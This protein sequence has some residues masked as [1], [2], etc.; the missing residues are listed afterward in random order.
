MLKLERTNLTGCEDR[1]ISRWDARWYAR[2]AY[3]LGVRY[4]GGCC[5]FQPFHVRA[6]AEELAAERGGRLPEASAMTDLGLAI[7]RKIGGDGG[8]QRQNEMY[9]KK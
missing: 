1:T 5:G 2:A 4:V 7:Y 8:N 3:D 9:F 6:M